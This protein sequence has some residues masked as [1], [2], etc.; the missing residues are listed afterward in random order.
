MPV[1]ALDPT[2]IRPGSRL[3][4]MPGAVLAAG[5]EAATGADMMLSVYAAPVA[6]PALIQT[7]VAHG[8]IL[9][10]RK[11]GDDYINSMGARLNDSLSRMW[12]TGAP[13]CRKV[14]LI[15]GALSADASGLAVWNGRLMDRSYLSVLGAAS[16]WHDRGGVVEWLASDDIIPAWCEMK[17]AHLAEYYG[18]GGEMKH[19]YP[20][21]EL[22]LPDLNDPLQMPVKVRDGRITLVTLPGIG[23][24]LASELWAWGDGNLA[25]ILDALT[26]TQTL[27]RLDRPRGIGP[28]TIAAIRRHFGYDKPTKTS[29]PLAK[30]A[31]EQ[32]H[33][34]AQ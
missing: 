13:Q 19:F 11:S 24:K 33:A 27:H 22:R 7:H 10:Q 18:P 14:L 1:I 12:E 2:E 21:I 4:D 3:P 34:V 32:A 20:D 28:G 26:T 16:R 25:Y 5:L 17:L 6:S 8:A 29:K 23:E 15:V 30:G 31:A 9:V